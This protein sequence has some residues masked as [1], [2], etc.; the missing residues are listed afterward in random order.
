MDRLRVVLKSKNIDF[1]E[2]FDVAEISTI[3]I[4]A[5]LKLAIFPKNENDLIKILRCLWNY[6]VPYLVVGNIS[7]VLFYEKISF[8][9]I[10]TARMKDEY[11]ILGN[12]VKVSAGMQ[13]ARF[14]EVLKRNKL[15]GIEGVFGIP[16]TIGGAIVNNASAFGCE[17][18]SKLLKVTAFHE[19]KIVEINANEIK[20]GH[21]F[22]NLKNIVLL[23]ALFLFENKSECDII[24]SYNEFAYRR[25]STQP[26][27]LTLGSVYQKINGRSAGFFIERAGLKNLRV[28]GVS[29][30]NKHANFFVN[31][32]FGTAK[33]FMEL[34][35]FVEKTVESQFGLT[36]ISE[37]EKVGDDNEIISRSPHTFKKFKVRS[38][39][40]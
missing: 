37:I 29:V 19:G 31:D 18:S 24:K 14:M 35:S 23:S 2:N 20:F 6:K 16:A 32:R 12:V 33:D 13:L 28:G 25:T 27:G 9:V 26:N 17:I 39:Q 30:S 34:Q 5:I 4:S 1:Y 21:H 3:K 22:S 38:W 10:I 36:L 8:P 7:N 11:E 40:E 15:G